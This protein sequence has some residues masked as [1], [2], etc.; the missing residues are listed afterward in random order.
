MA[1]AAYILVSRRY[2]VGFSVNVC[3]CVCDQK[4]CCN[5]VLSNHLPR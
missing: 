5:S 3:V 2:V 1:R 4:K